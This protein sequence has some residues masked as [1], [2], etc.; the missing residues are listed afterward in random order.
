MRANL[1]PRLAKWLQA[2]VL[3]P[4]GDNTQP[5]RLCVEPQPSYRV[6]VRVDPSRD[7]SPMNAGQRMARVAVGAAV[8]NLAQAAE[9]WGLRAVVLPEDEAGLTIRL[10]DD[11]GRP[12]HWRKSTPVESMPA[13]ELPERIVRRVTNRRW[14]AGRPV[15]RAWAETL[16]EVSEAGPEVRVVWVW[17]RER[18]ERLAKLIGEADGVLFGLGAARRSF[19]ENIRFDRAATE[20]VAE[21]LSLGSL[22]VGRGERLGMRLVRWLPDRV[23]RGLGLGRVFARRAEGL[24]RSASGLCV[25]LTRGWEAATDFEV[26]RA[27]ERAWLGL[28]ERGLAVQPMMSLAVLENMVREGVVGAETRVVG[29]VGEV[30]GEFCAGAGAADGE[31]VAAILRFGFAEP[32]TGRVGRRG[33]AEVVEAEQAEGESATGLVRAGVGEG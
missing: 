6:A 28:T 15:D 10:L 33:L 16:R 14:Y 23:F 18:V 21:G 8:E 31:R 4:S 22:E 26:G 11:C 30:S 17:Q 32:P 3:A 2:A 5:W 25:V 9:A 27:M 1:P 12:H 29:R 13:G 19:I 24:V 20:A 7:R